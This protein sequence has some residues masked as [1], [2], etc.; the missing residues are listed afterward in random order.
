MTAEFSATLDEL[1]REHER[2]TRL[3]E[4]AYGKLNE[5]EA[6][7]RSDDEMVT[8]TVGPHGRLK[9]LRLNPR[10]YR[11]LS[12]SEL[13][14]TIVKVIGQATDSIEERTRELIGPLLP[15]GVAYEEVFRPVSLPLAPEAS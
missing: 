12:P 3:V 7:A 2:H 15:E 10:V 9:S 13:A 5:S 11:R 1:T 4:E 8:A 14:D 6:V